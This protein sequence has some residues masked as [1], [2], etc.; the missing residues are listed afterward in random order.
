[1]SNKGRTS[2]R[3]VP[4]SQARKSTAATRRAPTS[5]LPWI[6]GAV[7]LVMVVA[8]V[9]GLAA[10]SN[11]SSTP[12]RTAASATLVSKLTSIQPVVFATVGDSGTKALPKSIKAPA[13]T[14]NGHPRVVYI[15]AE[16]CPYCAA[17]R[18]P[19]VIALLRF[20]TFSGLQT[21]HSSS[22]DVFANTQTLSFYGAKYQ[23]QYLSF[24][25]VELATNTLGSDG[26]YKTLETPTAEQQQ[27]ISTYDAPPYVSSSAS[28]SIPF[29]DFGGKYL[30]SGAT[31]DP[32]ILQGKSTDEIA[33]AASNPDTDIAKGGVIGA[34]NSITA[35]ICTLTKNQPANVCGQPEVKK[36]QTN[37]G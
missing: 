34:A 10:G 27:L 6:I 14:V 7:V 1:M 37:I 16:Y 13:L 33:T 35:A 32:A 28:G 8:L 5:R 2:K 30:I 17:E 25:A 26:R 24:E 31:Y 22:S 15:G 23:S 21:T 3:P 29:I 12:D 4:S 9:V 36:L 19:M 18:W 11:K 20:G